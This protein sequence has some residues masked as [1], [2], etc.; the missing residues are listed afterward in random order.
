MARQFDIPMFYKSP[1]I[2]RIKRARQ[3]QDLRKRDLLPTVLDCGPVR[4]ILARHFG[5]CFGV[6]NAVE[7]AYKTLQAHADRRIF[8]LSEMIHN[9][10]VNWDLQERGVQFI[11]TSSGEQLVSW[12]HL[13]P[14]DI[15]VVPAFGTT[16]EIQE[17][18]AARGIDP[19]TYNTTCPF[20]EKVW[21]RSA[22]LGASGYTVVVHGKATH[23][24]TRAT[25]SHSI[26]SAP[27]VVILDLEEAHIL[28]DI[29]RGKRGYEAFFTYFERTCSRG[30]DP[31]QHLVRIGVVNQTTMLA[32]ETWEIAQVLKQ[33][34]ADRYGE[35]HLDDHFADTS[36]TLCYATN[37]NQNATY[38]LIERGADLGIVV[39][40]YNSSNTSHIVAL[41]QAA[42]PTYF[43]RNTE[44]IVSASHIR[45]FLLATRQM[46]TTDGWLPDKRPLEV[47]LTCGAS[48]PD[49]IVDGVL[50]RVLSFF[51]H[52][53]PLEDVLQPYPLEE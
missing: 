29:I 1:V 27:T 6:E 16:L 17:T 7:I 15:V 45:H 13:T 44:E 53:R 49:A 43:I 3:L 10:N 37:E 30:F 42:M 34:M 18:L 14:E 23:E 52:T 24:E 9:P 38:A 2:S 25:F 39:G 51:E 4:F 33:A 5:F 50:F 48:C 28:A 26:R 46:T 31:E 32:S 11:F 35:K 36:D 21:K 40:G 19:Y 8:F 41:C 47:A 20:V 22:Q 12:D